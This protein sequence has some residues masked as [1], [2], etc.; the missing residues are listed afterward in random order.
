MSWEGDMRRFLMV[1]IDLTLIACA[2][3]FA[4]ALRDD[5]VVVPSRISALLP[6]LLLTLAV[7][8]GVLAAFGTGR[9]IWR[10]TTPRD[11]L[12]LALVSVLIVAGSVSLGFAFNRLEGIPRSVPVLQG[13]V[14]LFALVGTRVLLRLR[15]M[16][17]QRPRPLQAMTREAPPRTVLVVGLNRLTEAYLLSV[18]ELAGERVRVAGLLGRREGDVGRIVL[19]HP[20]LGLPEQIATVLQK[21]ELH[22]VAVDEVV[23]ATHFSKLTPAAREALL[24]VEHA[25]KI[26]VRYL[27]ESLGLEAQ[28]ATTSL[29]ATSQFS[30]AAFALKP[31]QLAVLAA[32]PY[33]RLKRII[34]VAGAALGLV[35]LAPVMALVAVL[36]AIDI[37]LPLVFAQQRLGLG[38]RPFRLLKFRTMGPSHDADGRRIPDTERLSAIGR[39][40]RRTRLDELPQLWH[41]L[42]GDMSFIGPRPLLAVDQSPD[43]ALR[44][45]VRPGITG[46]AQVI[47]G[48]D[49]SP[50]DKAALDVW[51]VQHASLWLDLEIVLRTIPLLLLGERINRAAIERAWRDLT[52]AGICQ[53]DLSDGRFGPAIQLSGAARRAA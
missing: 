23:V 18:H 11:Y 3:V 21:L 50:L 16:A 17:R 47:G 26:S 13:L 49:I 42:V 7:A 2:T 32:R 45:L 53:I 37:G 1:L 10:L 33:W 14:M 27:A 51:Y 39:L 41:V 12:N 15:H 34:D 38:G 22:G 40:L 44:L 8:T 52:L 5:F 20:V 19:E 6:Y 29:T 9:T 24:D 48:R 25:G 43:F 30:K 35:L 28:L 36:V 31:A 4:S 46:W